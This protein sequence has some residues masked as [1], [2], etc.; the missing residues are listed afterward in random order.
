MQKALRVLIV[1]DS[2]LH[3]KLLLTEFRRNNIEIQSHH[4]DKAGDFTAALDTQ[5]WDLIICDYFLTDF[6]ALT[7]LRIFKER[8]IDIPFIIVSG[9]IGEEIAVEAMK[10]GAD[11]YVMKGNL[12]RLIPAVQRELRQAA[13]RR[14]Q[15]EGAKALN[16]SEERLRILFEF[17]PDAYFLNDLEGRLVDGNKAAEELTGYARQ[18]LIGK[19]LLELD[20][21]DPGEKAKVLSSLITSADGR[22][23]GPDEFDLRKKSGTA[24]AVEVRTYPVTIQGKTLVLAIARDI[25]ERKK[26][27]QSLNLLK[28]SV[29]NA[30]DAAYWIDRDGN[31]IYLNDS[32]CSSLG[33]KRSEL[34]SMKIYDVN[35]L[36]TAEIWS[37]LWKGFAEN[38]TITLQSI[39]RRKDGKEFPVEIVSTFVTSGGKQYL[40]GFARDIT[41]RKHA[42][43]TLR[44]SEA[45]FRSYFGLPLIGI[46]ITS[47]EK[48]WVEANDGVCSML[49]YSREELLR[50]TWAELTHPDDLAADVEQFNRLLDG[51]IESYSL[52]K[53]FIH[54]NGENVWTSIAVGC[55][56][57]ES[58]KV[59]FIV[60]YLVDITQRKKAE[61]A[62]TLLTTALESTA[63][64]VAITDLKGKIVWVNK[65]F[66]SMTGYEAREVIGQNPRILKSGRQEDSYYKDLWKTISAGNVWKGELINKKKDGSLYTEEMTITPVMEATGEIGSFIAVKQ[67]ITERK[68]AEHQIRQSHQ[69]LNS[70][71]DNSRDG[72]ILED[73]EG[74]VTFV[75][76]AFVKL[77]RYGDENELIGRHAWIDQAPAERDR[78]VQYGNRRLR[79]EPAPAIYEFTGTCK[80]GVRI[81]LEVSVA[82]TEIGGK[83]HTLSVV[84][85]IR[86]RKQAEL[87]RHL[88]EDRVRQAQK[89]EAIGTLAGGI[90]HDF[91]NILGI[92]MAYATL[93]QRG[94]YK[95]T[96]TPVYADTIVKA[97]ERGSTLVKQ[98]LTFA[99]KSEVSVDAVQVNYNISELVGMLQETFPKTIEFSLNPDKNIPIIAVDSGQLNQAMMNLCVNARDAILEANKSGRR[100]STIT[101]STSTVFGAML[102]NRFTAATADEYVA[103]S[104]SDT[105]TGMDERARQRIFE[106]FFTTKEVGKGTGLGLAVVYGIVQSHNGFVDV[107]SEPGA[108]STFTLY[109]PVADRSLKQAGEVTKKAIEIAGG[110]ETILLIEDE[111][112]L[113]H[114]LASVL[115]AKGYTV[116]A[117][118]D[119]EQ[120]LRMFTENKSGIQLV[121]SD[122]GLPRLSGADAV[123]EMMKMRPGLKCVIASGYMEPNQRAEVSKSGVKDFIQKPY[124]PLD[125]TRKIRDMLDLKR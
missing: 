5:E 18:E 48:G 24:V 37:D 47:P 8:S 4:V 44:E 113:R 60:A 76:S 62:R 122:F 61:E 116:L 35:P 120:G 26:A 71:L 64:G 19:T 89:M 83:K 22:P 68:Q 34:M 53:R 41:E 74:I 85:D 46:A 40:C 43:E 84:R 82:V 103:I 78:I 15:R 21:L 9:S 108:G 23:T 65:A 58:R 81:N 102:R 109:F 16:S 11:D 70:I 28:S 49:G 57:D 72:I 31:F 1:E 39:H 32:A 125:V 99:R 73:E 59:K 90:A 13:L 94:K 112:A 52:D 107:Q 96:D 10:A 101:I 95:P 119:G 88:L 30:S 12:K 124:D 51:Q 42:E 117:A 25:T 105:G 91:N 20:L 3:L 93:L 66:T 17:A 75:N 123:K 67:H 115:Q 69:L 92:I 121:L 104:V 63:N 54:K 45:R 86:D 100:K 114:L 110:K 36:A 7:A 111:D 56:R 118:P 27:E 14:E 77:F 97:A 87:D 2:D 29:D 55:V 79:G 33:Y 80:D 6:D 50:T 98:I 106:P 38:R